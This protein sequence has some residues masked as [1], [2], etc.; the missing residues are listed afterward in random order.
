MKMSREKILKRIVNK[1]RDNMK[2]HAKRVAWIFAVIATFLLLVFKLSEPLL[3][4]LF[5]I[6]ATLVTLTWHC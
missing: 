4:F 6:S 2:T 3:G 1:D 5:L